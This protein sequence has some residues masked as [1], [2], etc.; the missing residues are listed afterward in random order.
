MLLGLF[1]TPANGQQLL[2]SFLHIPIVILKA[3][4]DQHPGHYLR[5]YRMNRAQYGYTPTEYQNELAD[6]RR[7]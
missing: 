1:V 5:I 6:F 3:L 4:T 2:L 7:G